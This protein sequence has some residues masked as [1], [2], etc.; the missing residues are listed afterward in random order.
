MSWA[1]LVIGKF[2]PPHAGHH[3]PDQV[4]ATPVRAGH[5]WW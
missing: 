2:Y 3:S 4:A 5:A 1:R